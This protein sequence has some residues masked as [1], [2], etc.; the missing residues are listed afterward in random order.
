LE[1]LVA[2]PMGN[3]GGFGHTELVIPNLSTQGY[4]EPR[5][6]RGFPFQPDDHLV[7]TG[8]QLGGRP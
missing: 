2:E 8:G 5:G 6:A 7:Y 3:G 4:I 1:N